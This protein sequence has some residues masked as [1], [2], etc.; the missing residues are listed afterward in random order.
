MSMI[1]IME[2]TISNVNSVYNGRLSGIC[3]EDIFDPQKTYNVFLEVSSRT[4]ERTM[5]QE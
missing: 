5:E 3:E 1:F 4:E 2:G